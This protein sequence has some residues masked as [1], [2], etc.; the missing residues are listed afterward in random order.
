MQNYVYVASFTGNVLIVGRTGYRK[1]YFT[2]KLPVN[3]FFGKLKREEWVSYINL[4]EE[5]KAE[6]ESYFSCNVGFHFPK[7]IEKFEDLLEV[8]KAC[9]RMSKRNNNDDHTSSSDNKI[10]NDSDGFGEKTTRDQIIVMDD[11]SGLADT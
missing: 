2:Q 4:D 9:S 7:S 8:F 11:V 6:I 1:T 5:R 3:K 10:F